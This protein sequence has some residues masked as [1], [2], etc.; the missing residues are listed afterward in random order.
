M[1]RIVSLNESKRAS[2]K[3]RALTRVAY[4]NYSSE[5]SRLSSFVSTPG[6]PHD[7]SFTATP[8]TLAASGFFWQPRPGLQDRCSCFHCGLALVGWDPKDVPTEE[9]RR[10]APE[11]TFLQSLENPSK[12][13]DKRSSSANEKPRGYLEVLEKAE[14]RKQAMLN[15]WNARGDKAQLQ[16]RRKFI[17]NVILASMHLDL[18]SI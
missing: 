3:A 7:E 12:A 16:R 18:D 6:W 5:A 9:H 8:K 4:P 1:D 14:K 11:C 13:G 10:L 15:D 2:K 17:G